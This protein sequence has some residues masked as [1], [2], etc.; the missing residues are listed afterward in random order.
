MRGL[1][2]GGLVVAAFT[3]LFWAAEYRQR[4]SQAEVT[5]AVYAEFGPGRRITCVAQDGNGANWN[6]LSLRWGDD[7]AC[8]QVF[9]SWAG[10]IRIS[11]ETV[12]C[13]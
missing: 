5:R 7:P 9:V 10:A 11:H 2:F 4:A 8:R 3:G 13:E 1:L 12:F 6:C